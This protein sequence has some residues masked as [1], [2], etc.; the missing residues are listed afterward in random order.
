M[1]N[2]NAAFPAEKV[3]KTTHLSGWHKL[4]GLHTWRY[5][6]CQVR[7]MYKTNTP[8]NLRNI[9]SELTYEVS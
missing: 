1:T 3:N 4:A 5:T 7:Y 8:R 9:T 6:G 2:Q